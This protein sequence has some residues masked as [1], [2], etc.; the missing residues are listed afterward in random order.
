MDLFEER[1]K[2]LSPDKRELLELFLRKDVSESAKEFEAPV[3]ELEEHLARIWSE[4][5]NAT[6]VGRRADFFE[7]G[8]DSIV[9]IQIVA[10]A[11]SEGLPISVHDVFQYPTVAGLACLAGSRIAAGETSDAPVFSNAMTRES[12]IEDIYPLTAMQ[13]GILY[14]ALLPDSVAYQVQ[15]SLDVEGELNLTAFHDAW[16]LA[17]GRHAALRTA[18]RWVGRSEPAQVVLKQAEGQVRYTDLSLSAEDERESALRV[19]TDR[20]FTERFDLS[21]APLARIA[22]FRLGA[23]RHR[24]LWSHH[25]I[26]LDGW[27]QQLLLGELVSCYG[28]LVAGLRPEH[29]S[30]A[31]PFKR[32]VQWA[33]AQSHEPSRIFW[34]RQL[35]DVCRVACLPPPSL[36]ASE[37]RGQHIVVQNLNPSATTQ[38]VSLARRLRVPLSVVVQTAWAVVLAALTG[39]EDIVYGLA[40]SGRSANVAGVAEIVGLL[41]N[42]L[43]MCVSF[44][45]HQSVS[46]WMRYLLNKQSALIEHEA[47][48]LSLVRECANSASSTPLFEAIFVFENVPDNSRALCQGAGLTIENMLVRVDEGYPLVLV[49]QPREALQ[50]E[51]KCDRARFTHAQAKAMLDGIER[52]LVDLAGSEPEE[53]MQSFR[54]RQKDHFARSRAA[55][56]EAKRNAFVQSQKLTR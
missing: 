23:G 55:A 45:P 52:A 43:P 29:Q 15:W 30:P 49:V 2:R 17:I 22:V 39:G 42:A 3:N 56:R 41:I 40:V 1:L 7:L 32:Y 26:V 18:I 47:S 5:L 48:P 54:Q 24:V 51:L 14:H 34:A 16:N 35:R 53:E 28:R 4:G 31:V 33:L 37:G 21:Q 44:P 36:G 6:N 19:A 11:R 46:E 8:G 9:L 13:E 50:L 27:S 25:H 10:R 38:L 20:D 12:G